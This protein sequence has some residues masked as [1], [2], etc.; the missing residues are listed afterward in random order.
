MTTIQS[1]NAGSAAYSTALASTAQTTQTAAQVTQNTQSAQS[2]DQDDT[3]KKHGDGTIIAELKASLAAQGFSR[4]SSGMSKKDYET[5]MHNF[6]H[7]AF[8]AAHAQKEADQAGNQNNTTDCAQAFSEMATEAANGNAPADL[9]AAF[10]ALQQ[11]QSGGPAANA[12]LAQVLQ[13]MSQTQGDS[14]VNNGAG[15]LIDVS[16]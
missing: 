11:T 15:S 2:Q 12:T 14:L 3:V 13:G 4:A 16:A 8:A 1:L 7:A 10:N 6:T 5:V 9:Q